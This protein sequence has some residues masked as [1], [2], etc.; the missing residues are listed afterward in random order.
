MELNFE[1]NEI[2]KQY[3]LKNKQYP[4]GKFIFDFLDLDIDSIELPTSIT[5]KHLEGGRVITTY[6]EIPEIEQSNYI[7]GLITAR[8]CEK[9]PEGLELE[10]K[11]YIDWLKDI[12]KILTINLI[13][14]QYPFDYT[15]LKEDF[16]PEYSVVPNDDFSAI[17]EAGQN[18]KIHFERYTDSATDFYIYYSVNDVGS[19]LLFDYVKIREHNVIVKRCANCGKYFI[20]SKRSDEIYCDRI[21]KSNRTCKQVGYEEKE[22]RDPFGRLYTRARKT[23]YAR[24]SYNSHIKDYREKHYEPWKKAAEEA[25]NKFKAKEDIEGFKKWIEENKNSF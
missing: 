9:N 3:T 15:N 1:F 2:T 10:K 8:Y 24:I 6:H 13:S 22:K 20:P 16:D 12:K 21:F 4:L 5:Q 14:P 25:R 18:I 23:Q 17:L 19:L 11:L 7:L